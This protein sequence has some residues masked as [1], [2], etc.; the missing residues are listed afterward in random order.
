QLLVIGRD[1][2]EQDLAADLVTAGIEQL[3]L[4]REAIGVAACHAAVLP[5]DDKAAIGK[6]RNGNVLLI[7]RRRGVDDELTADL[8]TIAMI[9]LT[10]DG[11]A[12]GV[13]ARCALVIPGD[14]EITA[15]QDGDFWQVLTSLNG[16]VDID[17]FAAI[18]VRVEN[19]ETDARVFFA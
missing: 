5:S 15:G 9:H 19:P 3:R 4:D 18:A 7:A 14:H 12:A 6:R 1:A 8:G 10:P 13:T 2:V 11:I 17:V 16:R